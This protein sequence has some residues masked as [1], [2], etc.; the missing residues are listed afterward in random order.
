[1]LSEQDVAYCHCFILK[2]RKLRHGTACPSHVAALGPKKAF[3]AFEGVEGGTSA[4]L[5]ANT[6]FVEFFP[7]G[8]SQLSAGPE[9]K[10]LSWERMT[11][12][13]QA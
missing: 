1:M 2:R 11:F 10:L 3:V 6:Y 9:P 7:A 4:Q 12:H 13:G 5:H 8:R